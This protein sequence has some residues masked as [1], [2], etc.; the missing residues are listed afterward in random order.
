M[1]KTLSAPLND[2]ELDRLDTFLLD[3]LNDETSDKIA[4]AGGDEGI[5]DV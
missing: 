3:R 1:K 5:L 4:R 2:D